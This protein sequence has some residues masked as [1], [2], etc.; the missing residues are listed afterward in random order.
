LKTEN[1]IL[2][3]VHFKVEDKEAAKEAA[4]P[5][6]QQRPHPTGS[7]SCGSVLLLYLDDSCSWVNSCGLR[8]MLGCLG[9]TVS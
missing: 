7:S 2:I 9:L 1:K 8:T 4:T 3:N 5:L 6:Q